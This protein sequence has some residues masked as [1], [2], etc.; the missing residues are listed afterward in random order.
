MS[1]KFHICR[2]PKANQLELGTRIPESVWFLT[3]LTDCVL[4]LENAFNS[5]TQITWNFEICQKGCVRSFRP[6]IL[7]KNSSYLKKTWLETSSSSHVKFCFN[8]FK[9]GQVQ[10][11]PDLE[12]Q[13]KSSLNIFKF[14]GHSTIKRPGPSQKKLIVL[15]YFRAAMANFWALLNNLV[16]KFRKSLY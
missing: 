9:S 14:F 16:W 12:F 1:Y 11:Q 2:K 10:V 15:F 4:I 3:H 5:V 7:E 13:V 6:N 8:R